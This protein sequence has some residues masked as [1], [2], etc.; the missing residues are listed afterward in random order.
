MPA[1]TRIEKGGAY[2]LPTSNRRA[3]ADVHGGTWNNVIHTF[4]LKNVIF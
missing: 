3:S 4:L 1:T 2:R